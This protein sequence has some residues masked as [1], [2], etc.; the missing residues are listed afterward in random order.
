[1]VR[2]GDGKLLARLEPVGEKPGL[3]EDGTFSFSARLLPDRVEVERFAASLAGLSLE[4]DQ[5]MAAFSGDALAGIVKARA[6]SLASLAALVSGLPPL[7]DL[8]VEA[9]MSG[10][11]SAPQAGFSLSAAPGQSV[12]GTIRAGLAAS[13]PTASLSARFVNLSTASFSPLTA[14]VSGAATA[15]AEGDS[16]SRASLSLALFL[17]RSVIR[18]VRVEEGSMEARV[19][20]L[21]L[22]ESRTKANTPGGSFTLT[23]SGSLAGLLARSQ[24]ASLSLVLEARDLDPTAWGGPEE[25]AG[26]LEV[27]VTAQGDKPAGEP[28]SRASATGRAGFSGAAGGFSIQD[29]G[30]AFSAGPGGLEVWDGLLAWQGGILGFFG[31]LEPAGDLLVWVTPDIRDLSSL[32]GLFLTPPVQGVLS[33]QVM[34]QGPP[35]ALRV[36]GQLSGTDLIWK[37]FAAQ[38][39]S[40]NMDGEPGARSGSLEVSASHV[41]AGGAGLA[42]VRASVSGDG[43]RA[44]FRLALE[45]EISGLSLDASGEVLG[46][47]RDVRDIRA[48]HLGVTARDL[49]WE[50][51]ARMA[52]GPDRVEI[53]S[54]DLA[55]NGPALSVSGWAAYTGAMSVA[56][57]AWDIR[58]DDMALR[59]A[60]SQKIQGLAWADLRVEN[61]LAEPRMELSAGVDGLWVKEGLP[62]AGVE[63][64]ASY[65]SGAARVRA[66]VRPEGGGAI[67]ASG[68][69]PLSLGLPLPKPWLKDS[70]LDLAVKAQDLPLGFV[71]GLT[72]RVAELLA[73]AGA[74]LTLTG[75]PRAP[76]VAGRVEI[77]GER[78]ALAGVAEPFRNLS[79][80]LSLDPGGVTVHE[81]SARFGEAGSLTASGSFG[82]GGDADLTARVQGL[83]L[84]PWTRGLLPGPELSGTAGAEISLSGSPAAPEVRILARVEG[85]GPPDRPEIP[86]SD[87]YVDAS[88]AQGLAEFSGRLA[89]R[90]GGDFTIRGSLPLTLA[91]PLAQ[92]WLPGQGLETDIRGNNL[93]LA[94]LPAWVKAVESTDAVLDL[95]A[96]IS[97]DPR[98][99]AFSGEARVQGGKLALAG[100]EEPLTA[101]SAR[102][103]WD[104]RNRIRLEGFSARSGDRGTIQARGSLDLAD[105]R[106]ES[107]DASLS[108]KD[109]EV[110]AG[111]LATAWMGADLAVRGPL[112][113]AGLTGQVRVGKGEFR[114]EKFL[115]SRARR[116]TGL[117]DV[118]FVGEEKPRP[119]P[120]PELF[121]KAAMDVNI[122]VDGPFWVRGAGAQVELGGEFRAVK[123]PEAEDLS[124]G[125]HL[126]SLR[127]F[128][129][130]SGRTFE[131]RPGR[132]IFTGRKPPDP[133]LDIPAA[134]RV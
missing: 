95:S 10:S 92:D 109:L 81:L 127:G 24:A 100:R 17:D 108:C 44:D 52:V 9:K 26:S 82:T 62:R 12:E 96:R 115:E 107:V 32:T 51:S 15:L 111:G 14:T 78:L 28:L 113:G 2:A 119:A 39:L 55:G 84:L 102:L 8:A 13:P 106:P 22:V 133:N 85:L 83:D 23:A 34:A 18:G 1:R 61:S 72:S 35:R 68:A 123:P 131:V 5:A 46:L 98:S 45:S 75:D 57:A 29:G 30:F 110:S 104:S 3:H 67:E 74:D 63:L 21:V 70:G 80:D 99:P 64:S 66:E 20:D 43:S 7:A 126:D 53:Q 122:R 76:A 37:D 134:Y 130:F 121:R 54:L 25:A 101:L 58:L 125:G 65:E 41:R 94:F 40:L 36:F 31:Q 88:Y 77:S 116:V 50:G 93:S 4:L 48:E 33:G 118:R 6:E 59:L 56:L 19:E 112:P 71:A 114:L 89:P 47:D 27:R 124:L 120:R 86:A 60:P 103:A 38:D 117:E 69:V 90:S 87:L 128:Y 73:V 97:G 132:V 49:A 11:V 105:G 129:T 16:L 91:W 79:A 42:S